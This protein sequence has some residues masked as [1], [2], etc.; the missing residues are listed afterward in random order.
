MIDLEARRCLGRLRSCA[1]IRRL[2][3]AILL[4]ALGRVHLGSAHGLRMG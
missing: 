2:A 4:Q 3:R 1:I